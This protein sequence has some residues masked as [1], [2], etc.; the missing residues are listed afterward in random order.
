VEEE[1]Q[2]LIEDDLQEMPQESTL[3]GWES[4]EY[5]K[6]ETTKYWL[7]IAIVLFVAIVGF[8]AYKRDYFGVGIA[9]I[10]ALCFYW[11][12][13]QKPVMRSYKVTQLGLYVD[14]TLYPYNSILSYSLNTASTPPKLKIRLNKR[15]S[16]YL[17][18]LL[19]GVEVLTIKTIFDQHIPEVPND[20]SI[21]DMLIN[22]LKIQ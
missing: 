3:L 19:G 9:I 7:I 1:K 10:V 13:R 6:S 5:I 12:K 2:E 17:I 4:L 18:I 8:L 15:S 16:P 20:V 11:Y 14:D 22:I 21:V